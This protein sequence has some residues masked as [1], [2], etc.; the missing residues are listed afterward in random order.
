MSTNLPLVIRRTA[1]PVLLALALLPLLAA[2]Q[3]AGQKP[4][5]PGLVMRARVKAAVHPISAELIVDAVREADAARASVLVIELDTPGGLMTSTR[6]I[7]SAILGA[8]TPVVVYVSPAG[9]QAAS[10]GFFILMSAD[11]AAMAPGTNTGAAHPVGAGGEDIEGTMA[12]KVEEDSSANIRALARRNGR[13]VELAQAAVLESRSYTADEAL[14]GKLIDLIAPSFD[15]LL[16]ALDGRTVK[17]GDDVVTLH[18]RGASVQEVEMS[19]MRRIL[20]VIANPNIAFILL[21][22]GGLGLYFE[23][24]NPGAILPGVVGGICLILAFFALSV[25]PV[26]YAGLALLFLALVLYIAEIKIVSHGVLAIGGTVA[27]VLGALMLFKTPEPAM[28]VSLEV[29]VS[30][31]LFALTTVGFLMFMALRA[32]QTPVRTGR[33]GLI[34]EIGTARSPIAPRGKVFVH[35]EIWDAVSD[36]PVSAGEPV[37]VVAVRNLTLAVRPHRRNPAV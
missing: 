27:L 26:S 35:G 25:L 24:M 19:E 6:D 15:K 18:T 28:R 7:S 13:N 29:I 21:S 23:L 33:E 12:K 14:E 4:V 11:I 22:L 5:P 8:Q 37:E 32:R 31:A 3:T 20:S 10:A 30:L 36:E 16:E 1:V 34:H 2:A 9:A 17:R